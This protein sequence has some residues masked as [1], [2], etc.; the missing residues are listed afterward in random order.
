MDKNIVLFINILKP[1]FGRLSN[2]RHPSRI[3]YIMN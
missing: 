3:D 2:S 1:L